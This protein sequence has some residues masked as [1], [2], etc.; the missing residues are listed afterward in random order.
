MYLCKIE[1]TKDKSIAFLET[2]YDYA[3]GT[4]I[5]PMLEFHPALAG[6]EVNRWRVLGR[7]DLDK[8]RELLKEDK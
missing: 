5:Y 1:N 2:P 6:H 3:K 7:I 4:I 8:A